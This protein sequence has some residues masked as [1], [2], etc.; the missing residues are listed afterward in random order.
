MVEKYKTDKTKIGIDISHWQGNIDFQKV[1]EAG[2]EFVY[3]RVGRG[4][5]IGGEYVI[6][7]KFE[8][9]IEG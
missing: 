7:K 4:N 1:K 5:G 2:V 3:I 9:N 6:D 8:E